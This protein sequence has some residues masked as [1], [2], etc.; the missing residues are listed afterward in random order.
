MAAID[1]V[2]GM[3]WSESRYIGDGV[4]IMDATP[5]MGIPSVALRTDRESMSHVIVFEEADFRDMARIGKE[6]FQKYHPAPAK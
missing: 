5:R 3:D 2:F 4:Y 6:L 1:T